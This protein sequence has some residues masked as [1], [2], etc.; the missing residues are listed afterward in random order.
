M[1]AL[2]QMVS[3][4]SHMYLLT[5]ARAVER[6][7]QHRHI[8]QPLDSAA[9]KSQKLTPT[10]I[11]HDPTG[12]AGRAFGKRLAHIADG[13]GAGLVRQADFICGA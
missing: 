7:T 1:F 5:A 8:Q 10:P 13:G 11:V 12:V 9:P 2:V 3:C 6:A 4:L